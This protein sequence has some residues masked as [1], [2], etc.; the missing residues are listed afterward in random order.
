MDE[1]GPQGKATI[2][3]LLAEYGLRP[4]QSYG[5]N[6]L[7]DPNVIRR[8]VR[9]ADVSSR[10]NVVEIGGGTGTLTGALAATGARV[11]VYEIDAGLV[12]VLEDSVGDLPN[13]EIRHEDAGLVDLHGDLG[14]GTWALVANLPYNV[15]T[16]IVLDALRHAPCI[17]RFV[18]MV[19][20]EVADRLLADPGSRNYGIPSVVTALHASGSVAFTA[21]PT[22]FYP[23]PSVDST[24]VELMRRTAPDEAERAIEIATVAFGQR[25]KMLRRSLADIIP[26]T[27]PLLER[28]GIDPTLRPEDLS[29]V[30]FVAI[31]A[32]VEA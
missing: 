8:I 7:V 1:P 28:C 27:V 29:P 14:E 13:V 21:P 6:F 20:R 3:G 17:D 26:D 22:V 24:V 4:N 25:R 5:Q 19:Q 23:S 12:R 30:D 2:R 11:V 15:G 31:A 16:G 10:S 9:L 18:I 32:E